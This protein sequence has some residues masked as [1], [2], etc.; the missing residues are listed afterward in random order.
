MQQCRE[1][2]RC[3]RR[4]PYCSNSRVKYLYD[5]QLKIMKELHVPVLDV[6]EASYLSADKHPYS[7]A[8][9]YSKKFNKFIL[10]SFYK[11]GKKGS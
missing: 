5:E 9:H 11:G 2:I 1:D 8:M 6:F 4:L 10:K 7:D 3:V